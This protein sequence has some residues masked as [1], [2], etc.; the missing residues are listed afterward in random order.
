MMRSDLA[1]QPSGSSV[2]PPSLPEVF[3]RVYYH[4]YSNSNLP[5]AER[6]AAEM[7]RL[8]FC[9]LY[10]ERNGGKREFRAEPHEGEDEIGRRVR[11]LFEKVKGAHPDVFDGDE[12]LRLDDPSLA[13]VVGALQGCAL[14]EAER[15]AI[16][17]AF[18]AI[19]GPGLRG[20]K[21]QFFT[22]RNVVKMCVAM[23][24][25]RPGERIIDP[26]CGSGGFLVEV[27]SHLEGKGSDGIYGVDKERD[28]AKLC[29]AYMAV[30]GGRARIFCADSLA[31][32]SWPP[33]LREVVADESYDVVLTNPPFG[34][35]IFVDDG[36]VLQRYA[37]G[38]AWVKRRSGRWEA[39]ET[40]RRQALQILFI[41]RCLQL[42][43]PGGRMAIVLPDG[44]FGNPSDRY[45]W[46]F[47]LEKARVLAVVSL[48][49]ETF[50]PGTHTKTSVLF[51]EKGARGGRDHEIFMAIARKVGHDKNGKLIYRRDA[52]GNYI[53]DRE[54]RRI[55]DD[56][57]PLIAARYREYVGKGRVAQESHLGFIVRSS[58][59]VHH[60][61]IPGYYDP[62]IKETLKALERTGRYRLATIRE[63]VEQGLISIR[64]GHEV[65]SRYYGLGEIPFVRTSDIVNWEI[66]VDPVKSIPEGV[67]EA[68][69]R[70]QDVREDDILLVTDGTFL[71]GRT[72]IVTAAD[73]KLVIQSHIRRLRC[74]RPDELHPYLLLYL[75]NTEV[76]Q[77]QMEEKTFVQATIS[78]IGDRLYE[79]VLP[80]PT[81]LQA[82]GRIV[83]EVS[84]I[85]QMKVAAKARMESL[86]REGRC[87]PTETQV[88]SAT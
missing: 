79:V 83:G 13:Y 6:L 87:A 25:P 16:G 70:K 32:E 3:K 43:K 84:A 44:V 52:Q 19:L 53:L 45:I 31:P 74:L 33:T 61:F 36:K 48:A 60:T 64:R 27:L 82:I 22:P 81:D 54:G 50:L 88:V 85:V 1:A 55:P 49:P 35:K 4:L 66:K 72:A 68:Y 46:E 15:D 20:E 78:T 30:M 37:L 40:V 9:K 2:L 26:A 11:G 69:R 65:G 21:G 62:E 42:L 76:V 77:R 71:I 38:R 57:L 41:E 5:R 63:L 14:A 59:I 23:L 56:D 75:L 34:A 17:E 80:I 51:L 58:A 86:L 10:D 7:V 24:D 12:R 67:Y 18:Q 47:I 8:I 39:T 73:K 29:Q 28:L